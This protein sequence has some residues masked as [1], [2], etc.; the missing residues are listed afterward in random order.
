MEF[1]KLKEFAVFEQ[2]ANRVV[3]NVV[4]GFKLVFPDNN[5]RLRKRK[6][7]K[8]QTEGGQGKKFT[9]AEIDKK[10]RNHRI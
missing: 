4:L 9:D 8:S 2:Y 6:M 3:G 1:R 5:R 10:T 7:N